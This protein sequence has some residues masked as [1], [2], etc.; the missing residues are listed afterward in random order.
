MR[1][2]T[3]PALNNKLAIEFNNIPMYGE[4]KSTNNQ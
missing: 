4:I 2:I 1:K 3:P